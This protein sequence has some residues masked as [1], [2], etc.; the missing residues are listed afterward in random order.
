VEK[1]S[2]AGIDAPRG[3]ADMTDKDRT[4]KPRNDQGF[5]LVEVLVA[6]VVVAISI[7]S[8]I[9]FVRKGQDLLAIDKHRR[10][11]RGIIERTLENAKYQPENYNNLVSTSATSD[12][13][14]DEERSPNLH[15]SLTVAVGDSVTQVNG[16]NAPY[17]P[18]KAT[19]T[20]KEPGRAAGND[21]TVS[22]TKWLTNIQRE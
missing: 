1:Y 8:V 4:M 20:W 13:V 22:I 10:M 12:V 21:E 17:R 6:S 16:I 11:A 7:F 15:G 14:L 3:M 5:T 19:V 18:I 2:S 9:A